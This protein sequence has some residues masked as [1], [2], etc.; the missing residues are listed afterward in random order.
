MKR[1]FRNNNNSNIFL[2]KFLIRGLI[3]RVIRGLIDRLR[4]AQWSHSFLFNFNFR[5]L[6][7]HAIGRFRIWFRL[8]NTHLWGMML[9]IGAITR[10]ML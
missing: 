3:G 4:E 2:K 5:V 9:P 8:F 6:R 1:K 7:T 10:I